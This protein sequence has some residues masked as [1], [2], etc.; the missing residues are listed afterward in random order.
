MELSQRGT[1]DE[2]V[3]ILQ[4]APNGPT[5][6][7]RQFPTAVHCA[8]MKRTV[9]HCSALHYTAVHCITVHWT[10]LHF[11]LLPLHS[12]YSLALDCT[13]PHCMIS[14]L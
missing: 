11:T 9:L 6:P 13:T 10:I 2:N 12:L 1:L 14:V 3:F 4:P 7:S 8:T 5:L